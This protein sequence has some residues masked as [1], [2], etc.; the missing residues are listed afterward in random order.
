MVIGNR[1]GDHHQSTTYL[2]ITLETLLSSYHNDPLIKL[3]VI[4]IVKTGFCIFFLLQRRLDQ[5]WVGLFL[6]F[7]FL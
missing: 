7:C 3:K 1:Y 2:I 6:G 4:K 5:R